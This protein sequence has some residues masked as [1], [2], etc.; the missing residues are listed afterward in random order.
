VFFIRVIMYFVQIVSRVLWGGGW[1]GCWRGP[2]WWVPQLKLLGDL[3]KCGFNVFRGERCYPC[4]VWIQYVGLG[5]ILVLVG[6]ICSKSGMEGN[7]LAHNDAKVPLE[8]ETPE[9]T[10]DNPHAR[11]FLY[12]S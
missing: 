3:Y 9:S 1:S 2:L 7:I 8:C 10:H 4:T 6:Q 5:L 12:T 11:N